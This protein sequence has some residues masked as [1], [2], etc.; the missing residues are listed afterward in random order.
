MQL[1]KGSFSLDRPLF[2][3]VLTSLMLASVMLAGCGGDGDAV[4]FTPVAGTGSAYCDNYRA[5]QAYKMDHG[6]GD[7]SP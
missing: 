4:A 3:A 1:R 5:W 6:E 2:A 7:E